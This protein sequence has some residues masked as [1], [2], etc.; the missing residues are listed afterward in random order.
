MNSFITFVCPVLKSV[1]C[2]QKGV[3][4]SNFWIQNFIKILSFD[5]ILY[6]NFLYKNT[7]N[8]GSANQKLLTNFFD[9]LHKCPSQISHT[10]RST[11]FRLSKQGSVDWNYVYILKPQ[12]MTFFVPFLGPNRAQLRIVLRFPYSII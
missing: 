5:F 7:M 2:A 4:R 8:V 3:L 11:A 1:S 9:P 12:I 10:A 6:M